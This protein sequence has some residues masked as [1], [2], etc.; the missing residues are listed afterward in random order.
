MRENNIAAE[1]MTRADVE[2][3]RGRIMATDDDVLQEQEWSAVYEA[4]AGVL[5][6]HGTEDPYGKG[7]YWIL[8][9]NWG[10]R[11]QKVEFHNLRML[12]PPII[13]ALRDVLQAY[14]DWEIVIGIDVP[15]K[16]NDWPPMGLI[17]RDR[18]IVDGLQRSYLPPPLHDLA[19]EGSGPIATLSPMHLV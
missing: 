16:E 5:R 17:V 9:E 14:A 6:K 15:G 4:I 11:Q 18:E 7:D 1:K 10:P 13:Y 2:A 12:S 8:D 19:Y 3:S